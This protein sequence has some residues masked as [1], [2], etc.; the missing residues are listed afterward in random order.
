MFGSIV[1]P[2]KHIAAATLIVA[3]FSGIALAF[4]IS[5]PSPEWQCRQEIERQIAGPGDMADTHGVCARY[6]LAELLQIAAEGTQ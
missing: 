5:Q 2:M 3:F 1:V 6:T 4:Q